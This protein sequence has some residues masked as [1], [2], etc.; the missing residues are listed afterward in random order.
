MNGGAAE[1]L[2]T[3]GYDAL[4]ELGPDTVPQ[5]ITDALVDLD[6]IQQGDELSAED[7]DVGLRRL[8]FLVDRMDADRLSLNSMYCDYKWPITS[9]NCYS[10]PLEAFYWQPLPPFQAVTDTIALPPADRSYLKHNLS[11]A[12]ALPFMKQ[13]SHHPPR[14]R[15]PT[16]T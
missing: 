9:I 1:M 12:L 10:A 15:T 16:A 11:L 7:A 3:P 5:F 4:P 6:A 2:L 14:L 13:P 8:N